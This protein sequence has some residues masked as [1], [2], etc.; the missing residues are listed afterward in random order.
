MRMM[1]TSEKR[2]G[3]MKEVGWKL[4]ERFFPMK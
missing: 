4:G 2:T 3:G 1:K